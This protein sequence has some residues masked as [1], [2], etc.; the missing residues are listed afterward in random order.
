MCV[1][2]LYDCVGEALNLAMIL[3]WS[4]LQTGARRPVVS[5]QLMEKILVWEAGRPASHTKIFSISWRETTG[6]RA[7]VC[8]KDQ[9]K[10]MAKLSASPTQS[11]KTRT[12]ICSYRYK[13]T[14][15]AHIQFGISTN[16]RRDIDLYQYVY[17]IIVNSIFSPKSFHFEQKHWNPLLNDLQV[18]S[19]LYRGAKYQF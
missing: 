18:L 6:R 12:H 11:Y 15:R 9:S 1:R 8:K 2:V 13:D 3:L 17:F 5:L 7:P 16:T 14:R 19:S 10:I 4:F